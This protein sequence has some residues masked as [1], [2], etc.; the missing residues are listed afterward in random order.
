MMSKRWLLAYF[1]AA[2]LGTVACSYSARAAIP[3][4]CEALPSVQS[5]A[6]CACEWALE[7]NTVVA[8]EEFMTRYGNENT[9][10]NALA[11]VPKNRPDNDREPPGPSGS[12][13]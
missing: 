4:R 10:C 2:V 5:R 7:N 12:P 3:N 8:I 11:L 13:S 9:A 6:D 1:G